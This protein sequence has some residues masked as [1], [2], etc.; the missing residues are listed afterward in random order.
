MK[1][2]LSKVSDLAPFQLIVRTYFLALC[3][4]RKC[5][6][7]SFG[8]SIVFLPQTL[9]LFF[10]LLTVFLAAFVHQCERQTKKLR[11]RKMRLLFIYN[12]HISQRI[13]ALLF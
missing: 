6:Y 7:I 4:L 11:R 3:N 12:Y 5:V 8:Q 13:Y 2:F 9:A 1:Y 10:V